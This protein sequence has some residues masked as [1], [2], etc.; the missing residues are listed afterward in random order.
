MAE[1]IE[2]GDV[3]TAIVEENDKHPEIS[4]K[5][6]QDIYHQIT[7]RTEKIHQKYANNLLIDFSEIEQLHFK[8]LQLCDIYTV[9]ASNELISVFHEKERKEQFTSF[10]RFKAY[11]SN[12]TRP[13]INIVLKYNFSIILSELSKPQEYIITINL[14]SRVALLKKMESNIPP[15]MRGRVIGFA[16]GN[17]AGI[18]VEYAD[19]VVARS[20]L[21]SFDEWVSGCK[22]TDKNK[23]LEAIQN[24]SHL[25]PVF[26]Q[27]V[28][29]IV[30]MYFCLNSIPEFFQKS[31]VPEVWA[32]YI[33]IFGIGFYILVQTT[34]LAGKI[35]EQSIDN[36]SQLSYLK[37]NKGD[38]KLINDFS[39]KNRGTL[40]KFIFGCIITVSL[41]II[42]S[43][44]A[45]CQ[46]PIGHKPFF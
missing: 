39:S 32:R 44:L 17:I 26:L 6:Y 38:E 43:K 10:D 8:I 29:S 45:M 19:Y 16:T 34:Y 27:L 22:S 37:L 36:I 35:I 3:N 41:G 42:S 14:S 13:T 15:F 31:S 46:V 24:K 25:I 30:F 4:L 1:I 5:I 2:N 20:F 40:R 33:S 12:A 9:I 28:L 11:N 23:F 7:G 21:E 18:S